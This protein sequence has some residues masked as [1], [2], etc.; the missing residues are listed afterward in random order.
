MVSDRLWFLGLF[1]T[2]AR[3]RAVEARTLEPYDAWELGPVRRE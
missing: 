1:V 3:L 2:A